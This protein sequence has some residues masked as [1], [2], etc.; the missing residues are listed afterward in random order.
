MTDR[1]IYLYDPLCG[2]CYGASANMSLL[3]SRP[4]VTVE[5]LPTGLFARPEGPLSEQMAQHIW[6]SDQRIAEATG[7]VFS[8]RYHELLAQRSPLDST[9]ATQALTAV[10]IHAPQRELEIL[11]VIQSARYVDGRDVTDLRV[12]INLLKAADLGEA[13]NTLTAAGPALASANAARLLKANDLLD[14]AQARGVPTVLRETG[15]GLALV[16][17]RAVY[18]DPLSLLTEAV[19]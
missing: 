10:S 12:V 18:S 1:F 15:Q 14:Q 19:G 13:A 3:A 8:E 7:A 17:T 5:P 2:W 6:T 9:L 16:D 11:S 4:G